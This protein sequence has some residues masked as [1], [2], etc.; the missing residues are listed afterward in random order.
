[1]RSWLL[2][3]MGACAACTEVDTSTSESVPYECSP[4]VEVTCGCI[5]G[6]MGTQ[7]CNANGRGYTECDC[8]PDGGGA[9]AASR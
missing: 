9:D 2:L 8:E 1:M 7:V 5:D 6:G 4:Y 3:A